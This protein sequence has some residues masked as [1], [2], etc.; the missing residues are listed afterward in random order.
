[1]YSWIGYIFFMKCLNSYISISLTSCRHELNAK[2]LYLRS[3]CTVL[4]GFCD[5]NDNTA[6]IPWSFMLLSVDFRNLKTITGKCC[7]WNEICLNFNNIIKSNGYHPRYP[8][9]WM[10]K[11]CKLDIFCFYW[12]TQR[13]RWQHYMDPHVYL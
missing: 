9:G 11:D 4:F 10:R 7:N 6:L 13:V 5:I 12:R 8:V 3:S 2:S 1:M